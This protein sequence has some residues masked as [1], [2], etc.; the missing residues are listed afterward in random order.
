[1]VL[2]RSDGV[3]WEGECGGRLQVLLR[4]RLSGVRLVERR[5]REFRSWPFV[6]VVDE[7]HLQT[8]VIVTT[9]SR[10]FTRMRSQLSTWQTSAEWIF[11][12]GGGCRHSPGQVTTLI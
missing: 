10:R 8:L 3:E 7:K 5:F 9:E 1:M 6:K 2:S 11:S 4:S 12:E